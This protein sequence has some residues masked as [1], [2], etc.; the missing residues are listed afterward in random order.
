MRRP[1]AT[2]HDRRTTN[3]GGDVGSAEVQGGLWGAAAQDWAELQE[4]AGAPLFEAAFDALG[5]GAGSRLLDVG[6]GAGLALELAAKRGATV[7]GFDAS[8]ELLEV[9]R[10]RLHDADLRRGDAEALPYDAASFDAITA[11]NSVQYAAEPVRAL[12]EIN[13]VATPG[14]LVAVASWGDPDRCEARVLIG[15]LGALL[16]PPPPGAGGP[17]ALASAGALEALVES[18]A[19]TAETAFEVS[20]PFEY[21]DTTTAVRAA[22]SSG[23]A[24]AAI[25]HAGVDAVRNAVSAVLDQFLQADDT[26]RLDNVM[27]VVIARA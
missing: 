11:F 13:R 10:S 24:R 4:P 9:A 23:P 17:F 14:A 19:L 22:L 12:C 5:V 21:A 8:H 16:P 2:A 20:T 7:A 18:A 3:Q 26:V 25:N 27:R 1:A 15:A 6:C